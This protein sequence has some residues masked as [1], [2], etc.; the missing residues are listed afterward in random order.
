MA[1]RA[2][3]LDA[4]ADDNPYFNTFAGNPVSMAAAQA[5]LDFIRDGLI[6]DDRSCDQLR[7]E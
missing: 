2:D 6:A 7:E 3:V 4:F 5:V 1:I